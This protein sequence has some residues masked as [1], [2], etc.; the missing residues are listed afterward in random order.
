[1]TL[2]ELAHTLSEMYNDAPERD[3]SAM[4]ILFGVKYADEIRDCGASVDKIVGLSGL[5]K[6]Y[7]TMVYRG[8]RLAR[9]VAP[10]P[11]W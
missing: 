5:P 6:S 8:I 10:R 7:P 3:K 4:I 1:M 9:Y 2:D 11:G